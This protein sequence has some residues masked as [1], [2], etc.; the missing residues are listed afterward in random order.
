[1][2]EKITIIDYKIEKKTILH[3]I[4]ETLSGGKKRI[5]IY[6]VEFQT[7]KLSTQDAEL[8]KICNYS[9]KVS[10]KVFF[11]REI[12]IIIFNKINKQWVC[13]KS[14]F[15]H[16]DI[17]PFIKLGWD[18]K[19]SFP[20]YLTLNT[21][22]IQKTLSQEIIKTSLEKIKKK[23]KIN[24]QTLKLIEKLSNSHTNNILEKQL[25]YM[26]ISL[27][28]RRKKT[29]MLQNI[30]NIINDKDEKKQFKY[31]SGFLH[32]VH[33]SHIK[34]E[35][36][37][38]FDEIFNI[39]KSNT[40]K[41]RVSNKTAINLLREYITEDS[42]IIYK[43]PCDNLSLENHCKYLGNNKECIVDFSKLHH[44]D[45]SLYNTLSTL[46]FG[47]ATLEDTYYGVLNVCK[48]ESIHDFHKA[49]IKKNIGLSAHDPTTDAY[50]TVIVALCMNTEIL[51]KL[52][53]LR[54]KLFDKIKQCEE[55]DMKEA[56]DT[57]REVFPKLKLNN[58]IKK[59]LYTLIKK[60]KSNKQLKTHILSALDSIQYGG[61]EDYYY[62][63]MKYKKK[64]MDLL[65]IK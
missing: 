42:S 35:Y 18:P 32:S 30:F 40:V 48:E 34:R 24:K 4:L 50:Y 13:S 22:N 1:M 41:T 43:G 6:D 26:A 21:N 5:I 55:C 14:V 39:Y 64:Y 61:V 52:D 27:N 44:V 36:K 2:S 11:V 46:L 31:I 56:Y 33:R 25:F 29:N 54:I 58:N 12:G 7:Y 28:F 9:K 57:L 53:M 65:K 37:K 15:F 51:Y 63:Y 20:P 8:Y 60:S 17:F 23:Y 49:Y 62:K 3:N 16:C 47:G 59:E 45:I 38:D 10:Q 19:L